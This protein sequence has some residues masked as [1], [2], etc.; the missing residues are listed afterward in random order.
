MSALKCPIRAV[1]VGLLTLH[2]VSAADPDSAETLLECLKARDHAFDNAILRY[3]TSGEYQA[4]ALVSWKDPPGWAEKNGIKDGGP[5]LIK[6]RFYEQMVVR[7]S[8]TTFTR[9]LRPGVQQRFVRYQRWSDAGNLERELREL[10]PDNR[11]FNIRKRNASMGI[12]PEQRMEIEFVHGFGFG[13]RIKKIE[14][15]IRKENKWD[16]KGTIQI[17]LEDVSTFRIELG[18]DLLVKRATIDCDVAGNL[19]HFEVT[20]EG[21]VDRQGFVFARSGHFRRLALGIKK[22]DKPAAKPSVDKEF[23]AQFVD[24]K[25]NLKDDEYKTFIKMEITPGTQVWDEIT[26]KCYR[27]EKDNTITSLGH[28]VHKGP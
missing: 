10:N 16:L 12:I 2:A 4:P 1:V 22:D 3:T 19:S 13:K 9:Q 8:D 25:F 26:N 15:I 23:S 17:W 24:V 27:V 14:S 20:T 28:A 18:D 21:V 7:G 5:D 11:L 6:F